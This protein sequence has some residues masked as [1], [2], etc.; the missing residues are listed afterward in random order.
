MTGDGSVSPPNDGSN[1]VEFQD[2]PET[3][4]YNNIK[5][6]DKSFL[7]KVEVTRDGSVSLLPVHCLQI[8]VES[9]EGNNVFA[10][11][12]AELVDVFMGVAD[13]CLRLVLVLDVVV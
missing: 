4:G 10:L 3:R 13:D 6:K 11:L 12:V 8:L 7:Y 9:H 5:L 2:L 1:G